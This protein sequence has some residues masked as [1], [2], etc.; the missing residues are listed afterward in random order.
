MQSPLEGNDAV[1]KSGT[2]GTP[3]YISIIMDYNILNKIRIHASI[4]NK[5]ITKQMHTYMHA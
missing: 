1:A 3:K 2:T 4:L 5:Y